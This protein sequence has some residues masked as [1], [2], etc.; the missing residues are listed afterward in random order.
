VHFVI[1]LSLLLA[2]GCSADPRVQAD[3]AIQQANEDINAHDKLFDEARAA[4]SDA[5]QTIRETNENSQSS[6]GGQSEGSDSGGGST[7]DGGTT[8][9]SISE[10]QSKLQDA[11]SRLEEARGEISGI[12]DLEVSDDLL[13]YSRT[14][15]NAISAQMNAEER[16]IS[17][18]EILAG[19][20]GLEENLEQAMELLD[21]AGSSYTEA[22]N[23]YQEASN[24]ADSNPELVAPEGGN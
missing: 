11:R 15:E 22:E 20:P 5:Q 19:D 6:E 16:E 12:Q 8:G 2:I 17:F 18:Y 1:L 21:E 23:G 10:A 3:K 14:L 13:E 9:E 4:Y 24:I 7:N